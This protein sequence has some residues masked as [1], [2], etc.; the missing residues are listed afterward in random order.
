M[1]EF[2]IPRKKQKIVEKEEFYLI[3]E[4]N[5][6]IEDLPQQFM[7]IVSKIL[8]DQNKNAKSQ[9]ENFTKDV[10]IKTPIIKQYMLMML[11]KHI[12]IS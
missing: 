12:Q 7:L 5:K 8:S 2:E 9:I 4:D 1:S 6:L 3:D 10:N 11:K